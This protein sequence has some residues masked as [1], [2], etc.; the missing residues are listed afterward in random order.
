MAKVF[1]QTKIMVNNQTS[2]YKLLNKFFYKSILGVFQ[3]IRDIL[4]STVVLDHPVGEVKIILILMLLSAHVKRFSD[5]FMRD[6]YLML[7][8]QCYY[9]HT[10]RDLV[11]LVCGIFLNC[12]YSLYI[13]IYREM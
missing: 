10:S 3:S 7:L 4:Q 13:R 9:P 12:I 1:A 11:S 2:Q 6:F 5:S 8:Y